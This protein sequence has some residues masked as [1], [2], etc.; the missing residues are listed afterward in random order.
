MKH[1]YVRKFSQHENFQKVFL[2]YFLF[3]SLIISAQTY[4]TSVL[5]SDI[6][7]E[8]YQ[9]P[10]SAAP[11]YLETNTNE[12]GNSFKRISDADE[13]GTTAFNLRHHYSKDQPWNSDGSLIKLAGYPAAILDAETY[14]FLYW[15]SIPSSATWANTN[16]NLM[17][18]TSGNKLVSFNV[19]TNNRQT[20]HTFSDYSEIEYGNSE[21]NMSTDDKYIG[22]I[23]ENGNNQTLI[24]Y[25]IEEDVIVASTYIGSADLDWFS[26]SQSG[27]YAV[28]CYGVSGTGDEQ[29]IKVMNIDLTNR[30]H[31]NDIINHGDLGIDT[32]GDDVFVTFA[33]NE[34]RDNDYY[35]KSIRLSDVNVTPM[36]HYTQG[37][38]IWNGHVSTRNNNRPGWA[39]VS[40]GCCETIGFKEIFAIK[41]DGSDTIERFGIHHTDEDA[42]YGHQAHAVPNRDGSKVMF[43]SNWNNDFTEAHPPSFVVEAQSTLSIENSETIASNDILV[44]P[45]PSSDGLVQIKLNGNIAVKS[46]QLYDMLGRVIRNEEMNSNEKS[47]NLESL[48]SGVYL[49]SFQTEN[50]GS[51]TKRIILN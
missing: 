18:G 14:E 48:P 32:N 10:T 1:L 28:T 44:Y 8:S 34:M 36:F 43:A 2:I 6:Q 35:M 49:L 30:R 24:V 4:P 27:Q 41:L 37:Y 45:N 20:L 22:L 3:F 19:T 21:G 29:G 40:E 13:F 17:Y 9:S 15:S 31:L 16:P 33:D 25:N 26:V 11:D 46:I 7:Y 23:G 50:N 51:I 12:F 42:G 39:Y 38:G 5:L 47:L